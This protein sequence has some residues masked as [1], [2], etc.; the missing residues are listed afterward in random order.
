MRAPVRAPLALALV[1][2]GAAA[3]RAGGAGAALRGGA[4]GA[5]GAGA[6]L[7][8]QVDAV[9][10]TYEDGALLRNV[11]A[12]HEQVV[13]DEVLLG[14]L[15]EQ[16]LEALADGS[17]EL[18]LDLELTITYRRRS[19][20]LITALIVLSVLVLAL[21]T[22]SNELFFLSRVAEAAQEEEEEE[23]DEEGCEATEAASE[24]PYAKMDGAVYTES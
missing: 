21:V 13:D 23:Q 16:D 12:Q 18:N 20:A 17:G 15:D 24:A 5:G 9:I 8:L 22:A 3:A 4:G 7:V 1:L 14:L 10:E 11:V 2:L 19:D 6:G